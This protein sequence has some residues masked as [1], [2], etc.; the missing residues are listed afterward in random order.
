MRVGHQNS[1]LS[2]DP[3]PLADRHMGFFTEIPDPVAL[4]PRR[5]R[6]SDEIL[7]FLAELLVGVALVGSDR[8]A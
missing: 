8:D 1:S 3:N 2:V 5:G 7:R 6:V 4:A